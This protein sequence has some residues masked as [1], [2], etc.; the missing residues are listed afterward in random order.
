MS[1]LP[2]GNTGRCQASSWCLGLP[3]GYRPYR[4]RRIK[5][6]QEY[7]RNKDFGQF[8]SFHSRH[9]AGAWRHGTRY[10]RGQCRSCYAWRTSWP[11][12][13]L[14]F[15]DKRR[16]NASMGLAYPTKPQRA[17]IL[18]GDRVLLVGFVILDRAVRGDTIRGM[19]THSL[20]DR[21]KRLV[22]T[23]RF[24]RPDRIK[25]MQQTTNCPK[26]LPMRLDCRPSSLPVSV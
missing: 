7:T 11:L 12:A 9:D 20:R 2:F 19:W 15:Q 1:H 5:S 17:I 13:S 25:V 14:R 10:F 4:R 23:G 6:W 16:L 26:R 18:L 24:C 21:L 8:Q 3:L 22:G